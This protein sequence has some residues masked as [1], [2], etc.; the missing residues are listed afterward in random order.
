MTTLKKFW[1]L[2]VLL[3][4]L[5]N[6]IQAQKRVTLEGLSGYLKKITNL[7][8]DL[9]KKEEELLKEQ[10]SLLKKVAPEAIAIYEKLL[11]K[12]ILF[13]LKTKNLPSLEKELR[14]EV[15]GL[16]RVEQ[17]SLLNVFQRGEG[18]GSRFYI[19][20]FE[21][22]IFNEPTKLL[23]ALAHE[24][25]HIENYEEFG[26]PSSSSEDER[27]AFEDTIEKLEKLTSLSKGK[28]LADLQKAIEQEKK[29]LETWR[30]K[31]EI[32]DYLPWIFLG[33]SLIGGGFL[34]YRLAKIQRKS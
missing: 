6:S 29:L 12:N 17:D 26:L 20:L 28:R 2:F 21:E 8:E 22:N 24:I 19:I 32:S 30:E 3:L 9:N 4:I 15:G 1:P 27:M 34:Y 5:L 13:I 14:K 18:F 11:K 25:S 23:T 16:L 10:I 31:K 7:S 33:V